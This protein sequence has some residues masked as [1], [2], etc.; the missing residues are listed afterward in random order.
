MTSLDDLLRVHGRLT[1]VHVERW[2]P[3][4]LLRPSAEGDA[5]TFEQ[6]TW[7]APACWPSWSTKWAST[8]KSVETVIDLVDQVHTLRRQLHQLG[9]AIGRQPPETREAIA[10]ALEGSAPALIR[11]AVTIAAMAAGSAIMAR[12]P[13]SG[14]TVTPTRGL[15]ACIV[16]W[17]WSALNSSSLAPTT[18]RVGLVIRA[19][20]ARQSRPSCR[21]VSSRKE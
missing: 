16:G 14:T 10:V 2:V 19:S 18:M 17:N 3:R 1:T 9:A 8:T 20:A 5:W 12:W 11:Q 7:H 21:L 6:S 13:S 15:I 4:G